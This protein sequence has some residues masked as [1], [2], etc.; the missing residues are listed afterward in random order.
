MGPASVKIREY[1]KYDKG[2]DHTEYE[3]VGIN[4]IGC[5]LNFLHR[6]HSGFLLQGL[7]LGFRHNIASFHLIDL[8]LCA[9]IDIV[10]TCLK[11]LEDF[12][13]NLFSFSA[14]FRRIMKKPSPVFTP[15]CP[16]PLFSRSRGLALWRLSMTASRLSPTV[17][18]V[19]PAHIGHLSGRCGVAEAGRTSG[20]IHDFGAA[21]P[22]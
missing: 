8:A 21:I 10:L 19:Q 9:L 5:E 12:L 11:Q 18:D 3:R 13:K 17:P 20:P 15:S 22:V 14:L 1:D 4:Q 7:A 16:R 6:R 2:Q